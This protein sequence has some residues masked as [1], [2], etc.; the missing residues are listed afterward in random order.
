MFSYEH[1]PETD[2]D[3]ICQRHDR[4]YDAA[5][6]RDEELLA[7]WEAARD[8]ELSVADT[9]ME[10]LYRNGMAQVFRS[11][12]NQCLV[13]DDPSNPF[14]QKPME[15]GYPRQSYT[16][17]K[18]KDK[19]VTVQQNHD[20]GG[21]GKG[22]KGKAAPVKRAKTQRKARR[23]QI[24]ASLRAAGVSKRSQNRSVVVRSNAYNAPKK[25]NLQDWNYEK[26]P[27][28]GV[29]ISGTEY[30]GAATA[31]SSNKLGDILMS[32]TL[33]PLTI[34]TSRISQFAQLFTKYKFVKLVFHY[35]P[36]KNF[37]TD[38]NLAMYIDRD[39]EDPYSTTPGT[40]T[41]SQ[42]KAIVAHMDCK[43]FS[44][45]E[46]A[47]T[48]LRPSADLMAYYVDLDSTAEQRLSQQGKFWLAMGLNPPASGTVQYGAVHMQFVIDLWEPSFNTSQSLTAATTSDLQQSWNGLP[49]T[50]NAWLGDTNT[51][52]VNDLEVNV[53]QWSLNAYQITWQGIA[54]A[55]YMLV[56]WIKASSFSASTGS[57]IGVPTQV[58]CQVI[59]GAESGS[60]APSTTTGM[61]LVNTVLALSTGTQQLQWA[62]LGTGWSLS[63][64]ASNDANRIILTE[65]DANAVVAA[66]FRRNQAILRSYKNL[67]KKQGIVPRS[68]VW[69]TDGVP[70]AL[71]EEK[72]NEVE[73]LEAT[74]AEHSR[75]E[76]RSM[77]QLAE[78]F[79]EMIKTMKPVVQGQDPVLQIPAPEKAPQKNV[80]VET[81]EIL[82]QELPKS[83]DEIDYSSDDDDILEGVPVE[84]GSQKANGKF[85]AGWMMLTP[86]DR[87][88]VRS[89]VQRM[90]C[91]CSK[92]KCEY[93][94]ATKWPIEVPEGRTPFHELP[95][96]TQRALV[97]LSLITTANEEELT[98]CARRPGA[99]RYLLQTMMTVAMSESEKL[100]W[101]REW[102]EDCS[103]SKKDSGLKAPTLSVGSCFGNG[104]PICG[105]V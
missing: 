42:Y 28:G 22:K 72:K 73:K 60:R 58:N 51:Y 17:F 34:L 55:L 97:M 63:V 56:V 48:F 38:G 27:G 4:S 78:L 83:D 59:L 9:F 30:I 80:G 44:V 43:E 46:D 99:H 45:L 35:T 79:S 95:K 2:T 100:D 90:P 12:Q 20:T 75:V 77:S 36:A 93:C 33:N 15:W 47:V 104:F 84:F 88:R 32:Q 70:K 11:T 74:V 5:F 10:D 61:Y 1:A 86:E 19:P 52:Y 37:T 14:C 62:A 13:G 31:T 91:F 18:K 102:S 21:K 68:S 57:N 53:G 3:A 6:N 76:E 98:I 96:G 50:T 67:L 85:L 87:A 71:V 92:K 103:G 89:F 41:I 66:M 29:R 54:G 39:V 82:Y 24:M 105:G 40:G 49:K 7:D 94:G 16:R 69:N 23:K 64:S 26:I 101:Y 25:M 81:E 8:A 65:I